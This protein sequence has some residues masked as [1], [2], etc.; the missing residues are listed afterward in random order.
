MADDSWLGLY[1]SITTAAPGAYWDTWRS[2]CAS[3]YHNWG[4]G[5]PNQYNGAPEDCAQMR[6]DDGEWN[7]APCHEVA[8]CICE[9]VPGS[10]EGGTVPWTMTSYT[11]SD[12]T[13]TASTVS[14]TQSIVYVPDVCYED[15]T[16]GGSVE[17]T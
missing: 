2:G 7:D 16:N 8:E 13:G 17:S 11:S 15:T 5:E 6:A 4:N 3:S 12:C 14:G 9:R 1:Q 10:V